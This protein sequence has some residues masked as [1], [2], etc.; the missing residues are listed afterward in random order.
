MSLGWSL[1]TNIILGVTTHMDRFSFGTVEMVKKG[2]VGVA[3]H[4]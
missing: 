2:F 3:E 4:S 1:N